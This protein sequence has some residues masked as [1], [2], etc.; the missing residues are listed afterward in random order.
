MSIELEEIESETAEAEATIGDR[1]LKLTYR[2]NCW[3]PKLEEEAMNIQQGQQAG[4]M[5]ITML[6]NVLSS[7]ELTRNG[8]PVPVTPEALATVPMRIL[9]AA[10]DGIAVALNPPKASATTSE[11]SF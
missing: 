10:L 3:T 7:W 6:S 2:P 11:S 5:L 9:T 8:A 1:K 4:P